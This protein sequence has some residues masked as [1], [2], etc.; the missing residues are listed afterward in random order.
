MLILRIILYARNRHYTIRNISI[1]EQQD[2]HTLTDQR[3]SEAENIYLYSTADDYSVHVFPV[4]RNGS[5]QGDGNVLESNSSISSSI[6][7]NVEED[8]I[9][10]YDILVYNSQENDHENEKLDDSGEY[11]SAMTHDG[12]ED[13]KS[14]TSI[15]IKCSSLI[16]PGCLHIGHVNI[17]KSSS[18]KED[19]IYKK[20][21]KD[22]Q[23]GL[24]NLHIIGTNA[25]TKNIN[26]S[27]NCGITHHKNHVLDDISLE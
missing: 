24:T 13:E 27:S 15:E 23:G 18:S 16:I 10:P 14:V 22:N 2:D 21:T 3:A 6:D 20:Y 25:N 17:V 8:Y 12:K 5:I 1:F 4:D 7:F 9:H 19:K 11:F 26:Q